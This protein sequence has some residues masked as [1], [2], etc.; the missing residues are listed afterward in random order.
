MGKKS[1]L[2][3]IQHTIE[4]CD[5]KASHLLTAVGIIFGFSIFSIEQIVTKQGIV[6]IAIGYVGALY[7]L[8][9]LGSITLL[10]LVVYPRNKKRKD[11][12]LDYNR[13]SEDL[14]VRLDD[15]NLESFI[16]TE[17]TNAII[18]QIKECTKIAHIKTILLKIAS[19]IIV[20]FGLLLV[21]LVVLLFF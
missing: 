17:N 5:N 8:T 20:V 13:H 15:P 21:S 12:S 11:S 19:I 16:D 1:I 7:L 14:F 10:V 4:N 18:D 2:D 6:R 9:F 3:S